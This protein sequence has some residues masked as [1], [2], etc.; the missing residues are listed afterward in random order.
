MMIFLALLLFAHDASALLAY[1]C[2]AKSLN[3]TIY[4]LL[5]IGDCD[6][7]EASPTQTEV[8]IQ[9]LQAVDL[10]ETKVIQCK[11]EIRRTAYSCSFLG[12]LQPVESGEAEY[13]HEITRE[14]CQQLH[15]SGTFV[16][17]GRS[18]V[19]G[20]I[21]NSTRTIPF[22]FAGNAETCTG[23]SFSDP[24]GTWSDVLVK[25]TLKITLVQT[26]AK[27]STSSNKL[28]LPTG[29]VC[30]FTERQCLDMEHGHSFWEPVPT[31]RCN[32]DKYQVIYEGR[33]ERVTDPSITSLETIYTLTSND[34]TFAL[35]KRGSIDV[36]GAEIITTEHPK[37]F[38][39]E[40]KGGSYFAA[41]KMRAGESFDLLTYI[42]SK[43]VYVER[44]VR[45]QVKSLYRDMLQHR[46]N[47]ERAILR[48]SLAIALIAPDHFA[49]SFMGGGGYYAQVAGEVL[50]IIKCVPVEV[51]PQKDADCHQQLR[52]SRNNETWY[53]QPV[54]HILMRI[55]L[56]TTCNEVTPSMFRLGGIWYKFLPTAMETLAPRTIQPHKD[57]TWQY[58]DP[59]PIGS[60][61]I[62]E[63]VDM[64]ALS[65]ALFFPIEK[66]AILNI[67]ARTT[68]R[69]PTNRRGYTIYDL[70]DPETIHKIAASS[71]TTLWEGFLRF[72]SISSGIIGIL[73]ACHVIKVFVSL[74]IRGYTLHNIF[75]WSFRILGAL[76]SS[77]T[78]L[79]IY[80]SQRAMGT[81]YTPASPV[82]AELNT[83]VPTEPKPDG[84][85][86]H[87]TLIAS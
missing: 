12:N 75:G 74:L 64:E 10:V 59:G 76:F 7:P 69:Q 60:T 86:E 15:L 47:L 23:S 29:T 63:G 78:N 77:T 17:E 65:Q 87:S 8:Q 62:Y 4:S 80:L 41:A 72:G 46:C 13:L 1:D 37:L 82:E 54:T 50:Y 32:Y 24:Y 21:V 34:V 27:V 20:L 70:F 79:M 39:H 73:A 36:C 85:T 35:A 57:I 30:A 71:R 31:D 25:G 55:P 56:Q 5:D 52:V 19:T 18:V 51:Q 2:S 3:F 14:A 9:L 43:F 16:F 67:L 11:V 28:K 22:T 26:T 84:R 81:A 83:I 38:V 33:A 68:A 6:L 48:N 42:N 66:Q 58:G 40:T 44:H 45:T 53:V 61:T 49:Y